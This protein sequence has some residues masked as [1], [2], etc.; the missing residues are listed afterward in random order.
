LK[1][2]DA[3]HKQSTPHT[4]CLTGVGDGPAPTAGYPG[5]PLAMPVLLRVLVHVLIQT[6]VRG[7]LPLGHLPGVLHHVGTHG[8][9]CC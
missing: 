2:G 6:H 5:Y 3:S 8:E 9:V 1:T 4:C 7:C